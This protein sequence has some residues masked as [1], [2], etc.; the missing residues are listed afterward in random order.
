MFDPLSTD[1]M[2]IARKDYLEFF[3][4]KI[5][6]MTGNT[7]KVG[8]LQFLIKWVGYDE[9]HNSFEPWKNLRDLA[10][11]HEYLKEND[12]EKIVPK[13]FKT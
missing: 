9:R 12:L 13:K 7:T 2:D 10:V 5:L 1:P 8:T 11:L 6:E 4:E 3:V